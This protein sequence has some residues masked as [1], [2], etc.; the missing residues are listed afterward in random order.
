MEKITS[1][2]DLQHFAEKVFWNLDV[3]DWK[4]CGQINLSPSFLEFGCCKQI[5]ENPMFWLRKFEC[6]SKENQKDWIKCIQSLKKCGSEK[7]I[8]SYLQWKLKK[9]AVDVDLNYKFNIL[10]HQFL[11]FNFYCTTYSRRADPEKI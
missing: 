7:D 8:S 6:L 4:I 1:N 3:E 9:E 11:A 10:Y 5:L 2:P